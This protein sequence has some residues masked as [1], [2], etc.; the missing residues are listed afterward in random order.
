MLT[1]EK[2]Q[3]EVAALTK[4]VLFFEKTMHFSNEKLHKFELFLMEHGTKEEKQ[5]YLFAIGKQIELQKLNR[6]V[7][8]YCGKE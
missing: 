5:H 7:C 1:I 2:L 8:P 6:G 3:E 4:K